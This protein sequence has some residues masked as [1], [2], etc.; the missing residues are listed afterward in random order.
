MKLY[1][2]RTS[3]SKYY[4]VLFTLP[5]W[6]TLAALLVVL[7]TVLLILQGAGATPLL[8]NSIM[9]VIVLRI[10]GL[11]YPSTV[12]YKLKRI[13]GL[14]LVVLLY[15]LLYDVVTKDW[16]LAVTASSTLVIAVLQGLDGTRWWRYIIAVSPAFTSIAISSLVVEEPLGL[17]VSRASI[18]LLLFIVLDYVI[19]L[20]LSRHRVNSFSAPDLGTLYLQNWLDRKKDIERVF[21]ALS[22]YEIVHPQAIYLDDLVVVYT[23]LHYGPFSNTG[24]S[25]LPGELKKLLGRL[26]YTAITLHGYGFHDRNLASS[27]YLA[28]YLKRVQSMILDAGRVRLQYHGALR[29]SGEDNWE[30]LM[31]VF[32]KLILAFTSRPGRGID[33]PPYYVYMRFNA[34]VKRMGLG[35]LI[36]VDSHN[37]EKEVEHDIRALENLLEEALNQALELKKLPPVEVLSRYVCFK[38]KS[39]GLIEGDA[40]LLEIAGEG[41]GR[42]V[43]LYL[44]GNNMKPGLRDQLVKILRELTGADYVEVFT[45]DEHSET[46]TRATLTYV[47]VHESPE[48]LRDLE[49]AVR[50][51]VS[52]PYMR[53]AFYSSMR[54]D[55]KVMGYSARVLEDLLKE[56]YIESTVLLLSY[57]FLLPLVAWMLGFH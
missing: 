49:E 46:G 34:T 12:F 27:R 21:E 29:L 1:K 53:G 9:L 30:I 14:T 13:L 36:L 33:D 16:I 19:Y 57:A 24:S 8:V 45:N 48:L 3:V 28:E 47:P 4:T 22:T 39:P 40:C 42:V 51:L 50:E 15:T 56:T 37:W 52:K 43:L 32:D 23:D 5:H 17:A 54:F 31:L 55:A 20:V 11:L 41:R 25:E 2:P 18:L 10:Y 7:S 35:N 6:R 38:S 26:G 44:R